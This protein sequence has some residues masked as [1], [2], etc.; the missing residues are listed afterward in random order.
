MKISDVMSG[1]PELC[2]IQDS[3][4][5][6]AQLMAQRDIG[7]VPIC[8]SRDTRRL[9]GCVTD[10]DIVVRVVA[11]QKDYNLN[12]SEVMSTNAITVRPED[13]VEH[14]RE[15]M[16]EHQIRRLMVVDEH[17]SLV[18]VVATAD[19]A[20]SIEEEEVGETLEAISQP[21]PTLNTK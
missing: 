14:A 3:V 21:A 16:E 10:R 4:L 1:S 8:E 19:L 5:D 11:E 15:L 7:M 6:C 9:I 18:G 13:D 17:G 12:V 2:T 20:R